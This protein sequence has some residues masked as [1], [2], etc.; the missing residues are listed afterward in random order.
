MSSC[1]IF[2]CCNRRDRSP[3]KGCNAAS[4]G[5]RFGRVRYPFSLAVGSLARFR[6]FSTLPAQ[7]FSVLGLLKTRKSRNREG[8]GTR[9]ARRE[10]LFVGL[11]RVVNGPAERNH[12]L[13]L[14]R[15]GPSPSRSLPPRVA[16]L[17][18][19]STDVPGSL[20]PFFCQLP[21]VTAVHPAAVLKPV[22]LSTIVRGY[23]TVVVLIAYRVIDTRYL[24]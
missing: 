10:T 16:A 15:D 23:V 20:T 17:L 8:L 5:S 24:M 14:P 9:R 19:S 12:L 2:F 11:R 1:T 7:L 4:K 22:F 3:F 13:V 21:R 6:S 18:F